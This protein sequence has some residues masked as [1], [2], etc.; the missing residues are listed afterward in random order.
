MFFINQ[1]FHKSG[2]L[3]KAVSERWSMDDKFATLARM[4]YDSRATVL[5]KHAKLSDIRETYRCVQLLI[6]PPI[7]FRII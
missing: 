2:I 6:Y 1:V 5:R 7:I 3:K 4:S